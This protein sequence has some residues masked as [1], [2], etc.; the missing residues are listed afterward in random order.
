MN[1]PSLPIYPRAFKTAFLLILLILISAGYIILRKIDASLLVERM[2]QLKSVNNSKIQQISNWFEVRRGDAGLIYNNPYAIRSIDIFSKNASNVRNKSILMKWLRNR[3]KYLSYESVLFFDSNFNLLLSTD[4][5]YGKLTNIYVSGLLKKVKVEKTIRASNIYQLEPGEIFIDFAIPVFNSPE[6]KAGL[7]GFIL[8][9]ENLN[10]FLLPLIETSTSESETQE[11]ILA[12]AE[13]DSLAYITKLRFGDGGFK[14]YKESLADSMHAGVRVLKGINEIYEAPDYRNIMVMAYG[15]RLQNTNFILLTQ[16]DAAEVNEEFRKTIIGF[17]VALGVLLLLG[18]MLHVIL[19]KEKKN[20]FDKAQYEYELSNLLQKERFSGAVK[21]A[22]DAILLINDSL[23]IIDANNKALE[24]YGYSIE[25]FKKLNISNIRYGETDSIFLKKFIEKRS[26]RIFESSHLKKNGEIFPVEVSAGSFLIEGK[27]FYN[28]FIRDISQRKT[29]EE[30][31]KYVTRLY[32]IISQVNQTILHINNR[33]ELYH[34]VCRI[35]VLAGNYK[36]AWIG[37]VDS[38]NKIVKPLCSYGESPDYIEN[39]DIRTDESPSG[40]GPT[41]TAVRSGKI[42]VSKDIAEDP[43]MIPF[44]EKALKFGFRSSAAV[45]IYFENYVAAVLSVYSENPHSFEKRDID[46]FKEISFDI[47]FALENLETKKKKEEYENKL[48]EE[49]EFSDS[50]INTL[51]E[52]FILIDRE[53]KIV[54]GNRNFFNLFELEEKDINELSPLDLIAGESKMLAAEKLQNVF[55]SGKETMEVTAKTKSGKEIPLLIIGKLVK[56]SGQH[57]ISTVGI[58]ISERK[59]Y[60]KEL[61]EMKE[62]AEEANRLKSMF[63]ANMSHEIRTPLI[64]IMGYAEILRCEIKDAEQAEMISTIYESGERLKN[65]LNDVLDLSRIESG[66]IEVNLKTTLLNDI[67]KRSVKLFIPKAREK[68]L[69]IF[70]ENI[71]EEFSACIDEIYFEQIINNLVSN[72][73]KYTDA[74][75]IKITNE[76]LIVKG[77]KFIKTSIADSGI[78]ITDDLRK[79]I[80]EPFRQGSEGLGRTYEGTGLGLTICKRLTELMNGKIEVKSEMGKGSV[81]EVSFPVSI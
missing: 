73:I 23:D 22:N 70:F 36:F 14:V 10:K 65:T 75:E 50:L 31:L 76:E 56:L 2:D 12:E 47:T 74:G 52:F 4:T 1:F 19:T 41:G 9:K 59:K 24:V 39:L 55:R 68:N 57:F 44:R 81:F 61:V 33:A 60:E 18:G 28:A 3:E 17:V 16:I 21:Y 15:S 7:R 45:P 42:V 25:E 32:K 77:K 27:K 69:N 48:L 58:D 63:L 38:S 62:K 20:K 5:A 40:M 8:L 51:P 6:S 29:A 54:K 71:D 78:G 11:T 35:F 64:G 53:Q 80:F 66:G 72:A 43:E 26:G 37:L 49:K 79:I 34:G 30:G 67:I 13:K 46:L